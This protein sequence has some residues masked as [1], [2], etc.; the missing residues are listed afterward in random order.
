MVLLY[1]IAAS[2][3]GLTDMQQK[4]IV[5]LAS[6][7][8]GVFGTLLVHFL[9]SR[10]EPRKKVSWDSTTEPGLGG[11]DPKLAEKLRI[12]YNGTPVDNLFSAKYRLVNSGNTVIKNQRIRFSIPEGVNVLELLPTPEP[13]PELKVERSPE[14]SDS[15]IIYT[16]GQLERGEEVNFSLV[17]DGEKARQW[18][19]KTS[20]EEG[21]VDV[22]QRGSQRNAEDQAHVIPFLTS[23]FFLIFLPP[24]IG[25]LAIDSILGEALSSL[26]R[27]ALLCFSLL[28]LSPTLRVIRD[29][30]FSQEKSREGHVA[31]DAFFF[32]GSTFHGPVTGK[33]LVKPRGH[34][35]NSQQATGVDN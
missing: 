22:Y 31:G 17:L 34:E 9:K 32:N 24:A 10:Q 28:H 11:I 23:L 25:A 5:G 15:Q 33:Q 3:S 35:S 18:K 20:N 2:S 19:A 26:A 21:N 14:S 6:A 1:T 16:V 30:W 8:V 13:D 4:L 7:F 12:S 27:I 29:A